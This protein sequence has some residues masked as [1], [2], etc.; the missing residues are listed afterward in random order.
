MTRGESDLFHLQAI[1]E[2]SSPAQA[3][4]GRKQRN[5]CMSTSSDSLLSLIEVLSEPHRNPTDPRGLAASV[6]NQHNIPT[7]SDSL[8]SL[9]EVLPGPRRNPTDPR[10]LAAG[11]KNQHKETEEVQMI[12]EEEFAAN[13]L[14]SFAAQRR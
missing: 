6:K 13:I 5:M 8:S 4:G 7:S 11:D 12:Q 9:I 1:P 2:L 10:M 3:A 14:Q